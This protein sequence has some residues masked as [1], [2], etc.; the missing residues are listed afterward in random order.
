MSSNVSIGLKDDYKAEDEE[1]IKNKFDI[2]VG[3]GVNAQEIL[4]SYMGD[5]RCERTPSYE[6]MQPVVERLAALRE[7]LTEKVFR[8]RTAGSRSLKEEEM[9]FVSDL[10]RDC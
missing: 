9:R 7:A 8:Q 10:L 5:G 4:S 6:V 1:E 2:M 3:A